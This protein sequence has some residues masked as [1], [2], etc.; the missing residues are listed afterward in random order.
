MYHDNVK[1]IEPLEIAEAFNNY[2]TS[3][4]PALDQNIPPSN[5][6]PLSFLSENYPFSIV[7]PTVYPKDVSNIINALKI[8][9]KASIH[10][11]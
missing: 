9:K 3:I 10:D 6:D 4:A 2:Y 11:I 5:S 7:V 1:L 8:K